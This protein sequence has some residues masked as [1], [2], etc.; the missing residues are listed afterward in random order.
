MHN[1]VHESG[2][3]M[4]LHR[5]WSREHVAGAYVDNSA[6]LWQGANGA[7]WRSV[8]QVTAGA[9]SYLLWVC[10]PGVVVISPLGLVGEDLVRL[11]NL[12]EFLLGVVRGIL[13]TQVGRCIRDLRTQGGPCHFP[14]RTKPKQDNRGRSTL[15]GWYLMA[16]FLYAFLI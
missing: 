4:D 7:G 2:D 1:Q 16:S 12:N 8:L 5:A 9:C 6:L 14:P 3:S 10:E 15:S 13:R 11:L